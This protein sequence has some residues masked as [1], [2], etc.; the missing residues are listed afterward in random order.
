MNI[1]ERLFNLRRID[2]RESLPNNVKDAIVQQYRE[3]DGYI[4]PS[5]NK[6]SKHEDSTHN[7]RFPNLFLLYNYKYNK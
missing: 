3:E 5:Y 1:R 7:I 2:N 4:K 6:H